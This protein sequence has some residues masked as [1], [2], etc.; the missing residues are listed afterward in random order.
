MCLVFLENGVVKSRDATAAHTGGHRHFEM[1]GGAGGVVLLEHPLH[2]LLPNSISLTAT[3][4]R[5]QSQQKSGHS[6]LHQHQTGQQRQKTEPETMTAHAEGGHKQRQKCPTSSIT[7]IRS[8]HTSAMMADSEWRSHTFH[9]LIF[10]Q[11]NP[12]LCGEHLKTVRKSPK[13]WRGEMIN[14][15]CGTARHRQPSCKP[16]IKTRGNTNKTRLNHSQVVNIHM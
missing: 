4:L 8:G 5:P 15:K 10:S 11:S 2:Q 1:I 13:S 12:A 14:D 7:G 3:V 6:H 9:Y 16:T